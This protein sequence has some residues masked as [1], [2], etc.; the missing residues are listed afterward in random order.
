MVGHDAVLR[1]RLLAAYEEPL[2]QAGLVFT[3]EVRRYV[4]R[5]AALD[6]HAT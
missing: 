5:A 1:A 3:P 4:E 6:P 2:L